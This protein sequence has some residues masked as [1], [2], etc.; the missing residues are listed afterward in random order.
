[1]P[2]KGVSRLGGWGGGGKHI[3][4][5]FVQVIVDAVVA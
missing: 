5:S 1:M 3:E 4:E 2:S